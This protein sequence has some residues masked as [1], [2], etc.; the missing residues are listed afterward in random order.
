MVIC[1]SARKFA[2]AGFLRQQQSLGARRPERGG[3]CRTTARRRRLRLTGIDAARLILAALLASPKAAVV[4]SPAPRGSSMI[5]ARPLTSKRRNRRGHAEGSVGPE[6]GGSCRSTL[7]DRTTMWPLRHTGI[8]AESP[9]IAALLASP[10]AA[11]IAGRGLVT[12]VAMHMWP[13]LTLNPSDPGGV[14][15]KDAGPDRGQELPKSAAQLGR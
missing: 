13:L 2:V 1:D 9:S 4:A 3:R 10:K 6:R 11:V 8:D 5:W 12:G 7:H 15:P 14:I